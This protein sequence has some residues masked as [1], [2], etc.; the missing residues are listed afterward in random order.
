MQL[1]RISA[2]QV[3]SRRFH[4]PKLF[5]ILSHKLSFGMIMDENQRATPENL[6]LNANKKRDY[7]YFLAIWIYQDSDTRK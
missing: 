1:L 4:I 3:S 7:F 5:R 6:G 2:Q